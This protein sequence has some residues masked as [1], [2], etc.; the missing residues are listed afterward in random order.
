MM[1][2]PC[3]QIATN[4]V[5]RLLRWLA[6]AAAGV[7]LGAL[8]GCG[9]GYVYV[10]FTYRDGCD[11]SLPAVVVEFVER[12]SGE[13]V[14]VRAVGEM[15]DGVQVLPLGPHVLARRSDYVFSL[16]GGYDRV[17]VFDVTGSF[18]FTA[19]GLERPFRFD[20]VRVSGDSCGPLTRYLSVVVD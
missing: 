7:L 16:A 2:P 17:G 10:G 5:H 11:E 4:T 8:A 12:R 1:P 9:P 6:A 13:R 18:I 20:G 3:K 15:F 19:G 14:A